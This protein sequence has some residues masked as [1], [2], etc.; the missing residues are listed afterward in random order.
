MNAHDRSNDDDL[1]SLCA[2][3]TNPSWY[4]DYWY[5]EARLKD[6]GLV[7]HLLAIVPSWAV[8]NRASSQYPT[9]RD[10]S[11]HWRDRHE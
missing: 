8:Q 9:Y 3:Q 10:R 5:A 1:R 4:E 6:S 2:F 11:R 7:R